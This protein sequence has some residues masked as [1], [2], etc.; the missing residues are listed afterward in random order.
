MLCS[1]SVD[2]R[3]IRHSQD[4]TQGRLY[5]KREFY[6]ALILIGDKI[7]EDKRNK[8]ELLQKNDNFSGRFRR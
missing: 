2:V 7:S 5:A 8:I 3:K 4:Y 1:G 6:W